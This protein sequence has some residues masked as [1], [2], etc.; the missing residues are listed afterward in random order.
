M[1]ENADNRVN[2]HTILDQWKNDSIHE[3]CLSF[4]R[5]DPNIDIGFP[6]FILIAQIKVNDSLVRCH[7]I[8]TLWSDPEQPEKG[9]IERTKQVCLELQQQFNDAYNDALDTTINKILGC[10]DSI[11]ENK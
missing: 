6:L 8:L 3:K 4:H 11:G 1:N 7:R 5:L 2:I 10:P 9:D